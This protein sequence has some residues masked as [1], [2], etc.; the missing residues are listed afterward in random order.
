MYV[1]SLSQD[2]SVHPCINALQHC[3]LQIGHI[4]HKMQDNSFVDFAVLSN[5]RLVMQLI[6]LGYQ[7]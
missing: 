2:R 5:I 6:L 3:T 1:H 4:G 7:T